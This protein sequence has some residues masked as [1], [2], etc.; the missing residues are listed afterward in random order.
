M[1][2]SINDYIKEAPKLADERDAELKIIKAAFLWW[3][4]HRPKATT[5]L[6][7]MNVPYVNLSTPEEKTLARHLV[8]YIKLKA[9][10]K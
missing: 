7:H 1:T 5:T 10:Q 2:S 4:A 8:D 6:T 9:G 3:E